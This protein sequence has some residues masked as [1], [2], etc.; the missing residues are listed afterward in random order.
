MSKGHKIHSSLFAVVINGDEILLD[1]HGR[2][3]LFVEESRAENVISGLDFY[4]SSA[5]VHEVD[6]DD[7][8]E[9]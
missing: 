6:V 1:P 9:V 2:P 7:I 4:P 3:F 5:K 8:G